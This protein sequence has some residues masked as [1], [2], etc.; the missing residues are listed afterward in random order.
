VLARSSRP[1]LLL[2]GLVTLSVACRSTS[3]QRS[4]QPPPAGIPTRPSEIAR[5]PVR[6]LVPCGLASAF[7]DI[8]IDIDKRLPDVRFSMEIVPVVEMTDRV[9]AGELEADVFVSLGYKEIERLEAAGKMV[10]GSIRDIAQFEL[11]LI[12]VAGNPHGV[13]D[14]DDLLAPGI[15]HVTMPPPHEN[16]VGYYTQDVLRRA[17]LWDRLGGKLVYPES[18][19]QVI[20][21]M[22]EGKADAAL[23]YD[24]CLIETYTPTGEPKGVKGNIEKVAMIDPKLYPALYVPAAILLDS[25]EPDAANR[26]IEYLLTDEAQASLRR[27][28]YGSAAPDTEEPTAPPQGRP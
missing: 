18:S 21:Y 7:R 19:A 13:Q 12:T 8:G 16:S 10:G 17:G 1:F 2:A 9:L 27:Y 28:G 24:T 3:R 6:V 14:L 20:K 15:K 25:P 5:V 4:M 26:V 11:A 23:V 22:R